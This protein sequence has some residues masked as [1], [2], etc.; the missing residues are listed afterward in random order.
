MQLF[1]PDL[2][3][4]A[5][6]EIAELEGDNDTEEPGNHIQHNQFSNPPKKKKK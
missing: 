6:E 4:K 2:D 3:E 1:F 5:Q